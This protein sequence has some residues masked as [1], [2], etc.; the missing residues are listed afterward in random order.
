VKYAII[1][2]I[3]A[4]LPAFRAVLADIA[5]ENVRRILC[6]GDL[7]GY[8]ASPNECCDL[9]REARA[10]SVKGNHDRAA[11]E[12]GG[13]EWF[14]PQARKCI[15]WTRENLEERNKRMLA[16]LPW[17]RQVE[18]VTLC[19]GSLIE[20]D[21]YVYSWH[22]ALP[23]FAV[24]GTRI[25]FLGHSHYAAWFY[26]EADPPRGDGAMMP[27]GG[28]LKVNLDGAYLLN[29]GA[30]GQPRD[31]NPAAAYILYDEEIEEVQFR[32]ITYDVEAAAAAIVDAGLP[33]GMAARLFSGM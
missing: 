30:V 33:T 13:E 25:G 8:G 16:P 2:D 27:Q 23:S 9:L 31:G 19:H 14:T 11:T 6:L 12:E 18:R 20:P 4:N 15:L 32:R 5:G 7:V 22:E 3:H 1:S 28:T 29:P 17:V 26:Y 21:D 10:I 24:M